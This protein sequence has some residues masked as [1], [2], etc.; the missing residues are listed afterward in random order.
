MEQRLEALERS[1]QA[2]LESLREVRREIKCIRETW[3]DFNEAYMPHL[4]L[5]VKREQDR[6]KLREAIIEKG[7]LGALFA[8]ATF[9][10]ASMWEH[11]A[12]MISNVPR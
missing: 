9:V 8:L 7:L 1:S 2:L 11:I 12:H 4:K 6:E 10:G 3:G 5:T